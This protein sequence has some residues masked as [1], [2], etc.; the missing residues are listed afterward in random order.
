VTK[1]DHHNSSNIDYG[2]ALV[3][4]VRLE[5]EVGNAPRIEI[6]S[7]LSYDLTELLRDSQPSPPVVLEVGARVY[8][9]D[10]IGLLEPVAYQL[11]RDQLNARRSEALNDQ[12]TL[13]KFAWLAAYFNWRTEPSEPIDYAGNHQFRAGDRPR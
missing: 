7:A 5:G 4:A 10:F 13:E 11:L 3:E 12:P 8:F 6:S 1:G 2:P 9:L